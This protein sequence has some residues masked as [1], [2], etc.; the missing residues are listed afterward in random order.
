M[1]PDRRDRGRRRQ[2]QQQHRAG[3]RRRQRRRRRQH[4]LHTGVH[5]P[6]HAVLQ[7]RPLQRISTR[8]RR[9][10]VSTV[11]GEI[12]RA[13]PQGL[14]LLRARH[15]GLRSAGASARS[16]R[17]PIALGVFGAIAALAAL[18]I[19]G[20]VIGRQLR[21]DTDDLDTLARHR[22]EP[23]DDD[24][25]RAHRRDRR[26]RR[27]LASRGG[28][29]GG[30]LSA[31]ADRPGAPRCTRRAGIAFDWTVLGLGV[32]DADRG[33]ERG[34]D[35]CSRS[36][37]RRTVRAGTRT[38]SPRVRASRAA[39][40]TRARR[41]RRSPASASRSSRGAAATRR[42]CDRRS[43]ARCSRSSS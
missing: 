27:R 15:L 20:Q 24:G 38:R 31:R 32:V 39:R 23:G 5:P 2:V 4:H 3:R 40:P 34:R 21:L 35:R 6:D 7:H 43:S 12:E 13:L 9:A 33:P 10:A 16:S 37:A 41:S 26:G 42:R 29:R 36:G 30:A 22:R 17:K 8:R 28:R 1:Q 19:A 11:E 18:L 14:R 25:R